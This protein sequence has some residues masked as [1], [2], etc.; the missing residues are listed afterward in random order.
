MPEKTLTRAIFKVAGSVALAG[1]LSGCATLPSDSKV[2]TVEYQACLVTDGDALRPGI[3]DSAVYS[4][5]QAVVTFG[6]EK[7]V[8]ESNPSKFKAAT[9]NLVKA[10][11]NLIA[12]AGSR[13]TPLIQPLVEANPAIHFLFI[14]EGDEQSLLAAN[15]ENLAIYRVDVYEAGLLAGHIAASVSE[16]RQ[17][18]VVCDNAVNE[19]YLDGVRAG[20]QAYDLENTTN[21][22][23]YSGTSMVAIA[24]V[25]LPFGCRDQVPRGADNRM[26]FKLVG[27][28]R[29]LY[30]DPELSPT[31]SFVA[32]T[33]VPQAGPRLFE[34]IA[35]DLES[36]F[37]GGTLGSMVASF[38]NTGL[39]IS[40]E[41]EVPFPSG[42]IDALKSLAQQYETSFK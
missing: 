32:A 30:L 24:D 28:G 41:H 14:T 1:L 35:A 38:G 39:A 29:D 22:T 18:G 7:T 34:I 6:I 36:E 19:Q 23:V 37:I 4:L 2:E 15:L 31:K 16:N 27:Y 21:T 13:F 9:N 11:C 26:P 3:A 5:N 12:V 42:E 10:N 33:V 17:L 25:L 20:A 8:V 40:D